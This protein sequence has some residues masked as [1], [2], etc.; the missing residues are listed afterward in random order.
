[1]ID[2]LEGMR[3]N[4]AT[5]EDV[6]TRCADLAKTLRELLAKGDE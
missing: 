5:Y 4:G 6:V 2:E 3:G 1:V